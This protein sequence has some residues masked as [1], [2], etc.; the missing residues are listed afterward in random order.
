MLQLV[1]PIDLY[2][3]KLVLPGD[4]HDN[5]M[6]ANSHRVASAHPKNLNEVTLALTAPAVRLGL[7]QVGNWSQRMRFAFNCRTH[8]SDRQEGRGG[9]YASSKKLL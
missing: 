2:N 3:V 1:L 8:Y 7:P 4:G 6:R 5:V 9:N